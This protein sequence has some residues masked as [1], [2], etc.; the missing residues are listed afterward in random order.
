MELPRDVCLL[1]QAWCSQQGQLQQLWGQQSWRVSQQ[2][3]SAG[4]SWREQEAAT[5]GHVHTWEAQGCPHS[6][7]VHVAWKW[8]TSRPLR[9]LPRNCGRIPVTVCGALDPDPQTLELCLRCVLREWFF[10]RLLWAPTSWPAVLC[11]LCL[12]NSPQNLCGVQP[13][14]IHLCVSGQH[15]RTAALPGDS[16]VWARDRAAP[17]ASGVLCL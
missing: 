17:G 15:S 14:A 11:P 6:I 12:K 4:I 1:C 7:P 10:L 16:S 13:S 5:Q 3:A 9:S 8:G 2:P